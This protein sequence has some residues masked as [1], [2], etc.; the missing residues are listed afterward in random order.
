MIDCH[1][2][3]DETISFVLVSTDQ[4]AQYWDYY[5]NS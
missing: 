3:D 4:K 5:L 2:C 1:L